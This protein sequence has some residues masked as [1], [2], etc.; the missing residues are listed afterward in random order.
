MIGRRQAT[1]PDKLRRSSDQLRVQ[2]IRDAAL[3]LPWAGFVLVAPPVI[4]LF[5]ADATVFGAPLIAVYL[6]VVWAALIWCAFR[7]S[8]RLQADADT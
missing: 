8:G 1:P 7:L 4:N 5:L 3:A 6:F 2:R